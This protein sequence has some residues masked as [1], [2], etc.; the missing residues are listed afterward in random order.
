MFTIEMVAMEDGWTLPT[1][2][3]VTTTEEFNLRPTIPILPATVPAKLPKGRLR[4]GVML[5]PKM[6]Y[7]DN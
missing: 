2:I 1:I 5:I 7:A 3:F 6:V 4:L